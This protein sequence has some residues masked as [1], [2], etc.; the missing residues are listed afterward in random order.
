L[1]D[2]GQA[3]DNVG[4]LLR[5]LKRE[6]VF[7]GQVLA[8]PGSLST[9]KSFNAEVY[10]LTEPEGGRRT[11]FFPKYRPQFF[12]RTA[13]VTGTVDFKKEMI[14]P[15]DNAELTVNLIEACVVEKGM[16]FAIREGGKTVGAGVVTEC[17]AEKPAAA[18][19]K[20][21]AG[22]KAAPAAAKAA[23]APKKK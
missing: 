20:A 22:G 7:R 6:E 11:P 8:K 13:D 10:V 1:L 12:F 3:G 4:L 5:S 14:M 19:K 18:D 17:L 23:A 16:R 21:A 9:Y 15:G 2:Q